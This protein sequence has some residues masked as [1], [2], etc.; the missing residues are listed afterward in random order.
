MYLV[1]SLWLTCDVNPGLRSWTTTANII[2]DD[3]NSTL[4]FQWD[5]GMEPVAL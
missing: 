4:L 3:D 1:K 2:H 5:N